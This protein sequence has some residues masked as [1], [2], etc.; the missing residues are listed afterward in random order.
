[1]WFS[2]SNAKVLHPKVINDILK[3]ESIINVVLFVL[4][5][6]GFYL[7]YL[8]NSTGNWYL[9]HKVQYEINF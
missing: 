6:A 3:I 9:L 8:G 7:N 2:N 4:G 1:M 5:N